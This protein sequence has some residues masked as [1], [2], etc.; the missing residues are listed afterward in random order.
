MIKPMS[1]YISQP[2][3]CH[4]QHSHQVASFIKMSGCF[5]I[6]MQGCASH[7]HARVHPART[8]THTHTHTHTKSSSVIMTLYSVTM[9]EKLFKYIRYH[10]KLACLLMQTGRGSDAVRLHCKGELSGIGSEI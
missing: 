8:H 6:L 3:I 7:T 10:T 4:P 5:D 2:L 9:T 1:E